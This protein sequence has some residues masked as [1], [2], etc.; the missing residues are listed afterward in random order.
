MKYLLLTNSPCC[1]QI[2]LSIDE[3]RKVNRTLIPI[4]MIWIHPLFLL[5]AMS[6]L[7]GL[8]SFDEF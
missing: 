2:N 6:D 5:Y 7:I 1:L 8:F 4:V 3:D